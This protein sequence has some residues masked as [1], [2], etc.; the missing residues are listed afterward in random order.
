MRLEAEAIEDPA[1]RGAVRF[2]ASL[3]AFLVAVERVAVLHDEL[4]DAQEAPARTRL[5][6]VLDLEV[7]PELRQLLVRL[8]LARVEA[9]GLLVRHREDEAPA[10]AVLEVEE[11]RNRG[12]AGRLPELD[13]REHRREPLLDGVGLELLANDLLDLPVDAPAERREGPEAGRDLADEAATHEQLVRD[14]LRVGG[15]L[16]QGRHEQL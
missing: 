14:R 12:A 8:D 2:E 9:D 13:R 7:V 15:I 4:A 10:G 5:V 11:L 16:A 1:V 6:A 3:H